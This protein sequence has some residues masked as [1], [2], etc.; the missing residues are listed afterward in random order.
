MILNLYIFLK[1]SDTSE[2]NNFA[3]HFWE[4]KNYMQNSRVSEWSCVDFVEKTG[5]SDSA[6]LLI[7]QP[8]YFS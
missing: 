7:S 5:A 3:V 4:S 1:F 2:I 6:S 8:K